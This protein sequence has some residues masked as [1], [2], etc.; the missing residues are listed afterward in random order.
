MVPPLLRLEETG[1]SPGAPLV[2][3]LGDLEVKPRVRVHPDLEK[4]FIRAEVMSFDDLTRLGAAAKVREAGTYTSKD[5]TT[6]CRMATFCYFAS[7]CN[8]PST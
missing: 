5:G 8:S 6:W 1:S 4:G 2:P 3:I 7:N